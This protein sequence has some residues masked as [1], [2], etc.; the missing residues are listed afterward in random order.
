MFILP[1]SLV[2]GISSGS[3]KEL[4]LQLLQA[5]WEEHLA[6][7]LLLTNHPR[8]EGLQLQMSL[9]KHHQKHYCQVKK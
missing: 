8:V 7:A 5:Q 2:R 4:L 1:H 6:E 3:E 9:M